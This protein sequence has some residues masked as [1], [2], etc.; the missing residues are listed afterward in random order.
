MR[1]RPLDI[2]PFADALRAAS[3]FAVDMMKGKLDPLAAL[4]PDTSTADIP[5]SPGPV[6]TDQQER[7]AALLKEQARLAE[8]MTPAGEAAYQ[9]VVAEIATLQ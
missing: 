5:Q 2:T 7:L 8:D 9:A 4:P 3:K 6:R 1:G